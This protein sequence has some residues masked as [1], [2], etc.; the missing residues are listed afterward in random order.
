MDI[1]L[2][3]MDGLSATRILKKNNTLQ[4]TPVIA[5]TG[6]AMEGDDERAV[7]AGCDGYISKPIDTRT[8]LDSV[9]RWLA[10]SELAAS[11]SAACVRSINLF[12]FTFNSKE[13]SN[14]NQ[15]FHGFILYSSYE[16][17]RLR[18]IQRRLWNKSKWAANSERNHCAT[19]K[20]SQR[21]GCKNIRTGEGQRRS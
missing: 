14:E 7:E 9:S 6:Y 12:N 10:W 18:C 4:N 17:N 5:L 1:Q 13:V 20:P 15:I 2:P 21:A 16:P 3:G 19:W 8:F 11:L